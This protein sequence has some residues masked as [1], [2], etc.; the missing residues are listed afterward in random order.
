MLLKFLGNGD[1]SNTLSDNTAAIIDDDRTLLLIDCGF[2]T[3]RNL[4]ETNDRKYFRRLTTSHYEEVII[5]I[6]HLHPD[7]AGSLAHMIFFLYYGCG[8][9]PKIIYPEEKDMMTFLNLQ[10]CVHGL[11]YD[12]YS[13]ENPK[14][15]FT[16]IKVRHSEFIN[17][18]SYDIEIPHLNR[19]IYYG[20]D[21]CNSTGLRNRLDYI[22]DNDLKMYD[23]IYH[24]AIVH[25]H[26]DAHI[27]IHKLKV[28]LDQYM[29]MDC[30]PPI[31]IIHQDERMMIS[32]LPYKLGFKDPCMVYYIDEPTFNKHW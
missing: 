8:I 31:H 9:I 21:T 16:P 13:E 14:Y 1:A 10:G 20:S 11:M 6:T 17:T 25:E 18:W 3:Y 5:A 27:S 30:M 15:V 4:T 7:H 12:F 2:T 28:D 22:I 19:K 29:N 24:E 26:Y 32:N 23:E